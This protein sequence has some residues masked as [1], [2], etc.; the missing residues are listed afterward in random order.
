MDT[1]IIIAI[2]LVVLCISSSISSFMMS[3]SGEEPTPEP[4]PE[5]T[6]DKKEEKTKQDSKTDAVT[7]AP[8]T[9][10]PVTPTP[11]TPAPVTPALAAF[12]AGISGNTG[13]NDE[14]GGNSIYLDR[15]NVDC[16]V[17]GIKRFRLTRDGAGHFRYDFTCTEKGNLD[18]NAPISKDTGFNDE[19]GGNSIFLDRHNVNCEDNSG[20]S[21]FNLT[22]DGQGKFRYN[23]K[24]LKSKTSFGSCRDANTGENDVGGGNS[25][26]LDRH[27]ISCN[28]DEV[29][30]QFHLVRPKENTIQYNYKCC[31]Y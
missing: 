1:K 20:L 4:T 17:N 25:I 23:F 18:S 19:G 7:S 13:F 10:A 8:V 6:S 24:C 16:G 2:V 9:P 28:D 29:I 31:K 5:P 27:D 15:H 22:R 12:T 14:G 30:K 3:G 11:V 26:F 21:Q